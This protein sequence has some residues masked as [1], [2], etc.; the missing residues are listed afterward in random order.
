MI[1][2]KGTQ[3]SVSFL[4]GILLMIMI[5]TPLIIAYV[6]S[7]SSQADM[8]E[9]LEKLVENTE[10]LQ[11]GKNGTMLGKVDPEYVLRAFSKKHRTLPQQ[12]M[13]K[14]C[15]CLCEGGAFHFPKDAC[16]T[17]ICK[18][19][20]EEEPKF[21]G[22]AAAILP[23]FLY[24][25]TEVLNLYYQKSGEYIGIC[26]EM[27]CIP[28]EALDSVEVFEKFVKAYKDC[29][30]NER[31]DCICEKV[32][33]EKMPENY[34]IVLETDGQETSLSLYGKLH[35]LIDQEIIEKD[36]MGY[37]DA[38]DEEA[39]EIR[40]FEF[41]K[42][43]DDEYE[44]YIF[45]DSVKLFKTEQGYVAFVKKLISGFSLIEA[46]KPFCQEKQEAEEEPESDLPEGFK[47]T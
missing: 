28:E 19:Y 12:C 44:D 20:E 9:M 10:E 16:E 17:G 7:S 22:Q 5:V 3:E 15:L 1:T 35:R 4:I 37:Y 30:A 38:A 29:K 42:D 45:Q 14:S 41:G 43:V 39:V 31:E 18:V 46:K 24:S 25:E 11:D 6:N 21:L 36:T 13:G 34:E 27:P 23:P 2:K 26:S 47:K 32:S 8:K 40:T 33:I